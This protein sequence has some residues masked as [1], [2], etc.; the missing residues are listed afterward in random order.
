VNLTVVDRFFKFI[1]FIALSH[2]YSVALVA[3]AFWF[4][5]FKLAGVKVQM[6][7]P[8]HPQTDGQSDVVNKGKSPRGGG[9]E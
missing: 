2:P 7:S 3:K 9:G 4:A 8:F 6:S 5:L 1:N